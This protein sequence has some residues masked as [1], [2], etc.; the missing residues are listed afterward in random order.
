MKNWLIYK[1]E[2]QLKL[3]PSIVERFLDE[4]WLNIMGSLSDN[5]VVS[6]IF[7]VRYTNNSTRSF[8]RINLIT[9]DIKFKSIFLN[10]IEWHINKYSEHYEDLQV[11]SIFF[12]YL[13]SN[14]PLSHESHK[15]VNSI[16]VN[17]ILDSEIIIKDNKIEDYS[18]LP[19]NMDI[20]SWNS[21]INFKG[22]RSAYFI[23]D[24]LIFDF[25]LYKYHYSCNISSISSPSDIMLHFKDTLTKGNFYPLD[26]FTR[27]IYKKKN[28]KWNFESEKIIYELGQEVDYQWHRFDSKNLK[29][30]KPKKG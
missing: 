5:Q 4:F 2:E 21:N 19:L 7:K 30:P 24:N 27:I 12:A 13:I 15:N 6:V 9:K 20:S 26:N 25:S 16:L 28:D 8:S 23:Y 3:N 1:R 18:F 11:E 14:L 10:K 22:T 17:S 29:F